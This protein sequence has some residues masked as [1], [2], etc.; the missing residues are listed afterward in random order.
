MLVSAAS[1]TAMERMVNADRG[2]EVSSWISCSSKR[3]IGIGLPTTSVVAILARSE[4][5]IASS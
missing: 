5:P 2:P 4:N 3:K 1:V